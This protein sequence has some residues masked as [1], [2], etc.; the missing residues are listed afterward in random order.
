MIQIDLLPDDALLGIFH[1]YVIMGKSLRV[2]KGIHAWQSLV[3]VC[4]R[5]RN[6]VFQWP[7]HLKLRLVCTPNTPPG[8]LDIWPSLPLVA[9]GRIFS[10]RP[11][12]N[13]IAALGQS[14]RVYRVS[15]S[16]VA[17]QQ[18]GQVLAAMQV[19]FPELKALEL[20]SNGETPPVIPDSFLGG[21]VP[22]LRFIDFSG[23]PFPG[24]PKL[25]LNTTLLVELKLCKIPHS[26]YISPEAIVA[27]LP[28]LSSL[29]TLYI[30]FQSPQ[31]RPDQD[32]RH[33]PP[34]RRSI[35][36]FLHDFRFQGVTEYLEDLVSFIDAPRLHI[37]RIHF[38]D[39][40]SFDCPQ[41]GQFINRVPKLGKC[42][43]AAVRFDDPT[44]IV[45]QYRESN[46]GS[47]QIFV[48]RRKPTDL[49]L[50]SVAQ[51]CNSL[52]SVEAVE[53]LNLEYHRSSGLNWQNDVIEDSLWLQLLLPFTAV[54]SFYISYEFAPGI[55]AALDGLRDNARVA[56]VLPSLQDIVLE[57]VEWEPSEDLL[58]H[59]GYFFSMRELSG[60]PINVSVR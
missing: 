33:P 41:L 45:L 44:R 8:T 59:H 31:S 20:S 25:L 22:R 46:S 57:E 52:P 36:P 2:V 54:E 32:T 9:Y 4:R 37:M 6:L 30:Q 47:F 17:D 58:D 28:V 24:L 34:P 10:S 15:L 53:Y 13:I 3:H 14:S 11:T 18:L 7:R 29:R 56:E 27:L 23:I 5:W 16:D 19:P 1:F 50:S 43:E 42:D 38:F 26:G 48:P 40:I 12:D 39:Q 60:H 49:W 55:V 35:L 51:V 21:S